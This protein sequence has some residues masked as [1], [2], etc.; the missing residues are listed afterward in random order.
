MLFW[1]IPHLS[2]KPFISHCDAIP[3]CASL[4]RTSVGGAEVYRSDRLGFASNRS[5][6]N[7]RAGETREEP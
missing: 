5:G 1:Q 6:V 4:D 2:I 7:G 3:P